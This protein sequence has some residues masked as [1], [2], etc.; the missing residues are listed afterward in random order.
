MRWT[1]EGSSWGSS[2]WRSA[3]AVVNGVGIAVEFSLTAAAD[4]AKDLGPRFVAF[5]A[6]VLD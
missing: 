2:G 1:F 5:C 4:L 6:M 3:G